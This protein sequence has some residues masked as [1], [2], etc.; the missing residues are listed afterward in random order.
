MPW[1]GL[2][3]QSPPFCFYA[4]MLAAVTGIRGAALRQ[5]VDELV[6]EKLVTLSETSD[7]V[8]SIVSIS[9]KYF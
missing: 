4:A 2:R 8:N 9:G 1:R 6:R 7:P 3:E 5:A